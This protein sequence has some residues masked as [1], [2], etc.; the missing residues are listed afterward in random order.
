[1][2]LPN[3]F[4]ARVF[5]CFKFVLWLLW[6]RFSLKKHFFKEKKQKKSYLCLVIPNFVIFVHR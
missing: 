4:S 3:R 5:I 6:G 2:M 1:M